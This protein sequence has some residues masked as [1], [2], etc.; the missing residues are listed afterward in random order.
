MLSL[1][2]RTLRARRAHTAAELGGKPG[3]PRRTAA[4]R[5]MFTAYQRA[6]HSVCRDC[7]IAGRLTR[8][9]YASSSLSQAKSAIQSQESLDKSQTTL[10]E[11]APGMRPGAWLRI[12]VSPVDSLSYCCASC[13]GP[14]SY[15]GPEARPGATARGVR[16]WAQVPAAF[17][18]PAC[19]EPRALETAVPLCAIRGASSW[20][21]R[22]KPGICMIMANAEWL[23][24]RFTKPTWLLQSSYRHKTSHDGAAFEYAPQG[25]FGG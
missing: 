25:S 23:L 4:G 20:S 24:L 15:C 8:R 13:H 22:G 14:G 10:L 16:A 3:A 9:N 18:M 6:L 7:T 11:G 21:P 5:A 17:S 1:S 19:L 2:S 12:S